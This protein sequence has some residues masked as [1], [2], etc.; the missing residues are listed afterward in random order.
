MNILPRYDE[1]IIP[2]EKLTE[3]ALNPNE[4]PDKAFAF[5]IALGYNLDNVEKLIKNII[6]NINKFPAKSKGNKGYGTLYEV[7]LVLTGENG[8]SARVLTGWIDDVFTGEMRLVS[9]YVDKWKGARK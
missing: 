4:Q 2:I 7:A 5:E 6:Q 1:A 3:Y 8:K 9:I